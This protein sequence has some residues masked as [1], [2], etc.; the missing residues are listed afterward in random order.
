[1][2]AR[3]SNKFNVVN[4]SQCSLTCSRGI[5][6]TTILSLC[7]CECC[8]LVDQS[9]P[10]PNYNNKQNYEKGKQF[11]NDNNGNS[12]VE[13]KPCSVV[14]DLAFEDLIRL[15]IS[16]PH[17]YRS[18]KEFLNSKYLEGKL[19]AARNRPSVLSDNNQT[20]SELECFVRTPKRTWSISS[21]E[22]PESPCTRLGAGLLKG[23]NRFSNL[24]GVKRRVTAPVRYNPRVEKYRRANLKLSTNVSRKID[25]GEDSVPNCLKSC[26]V[27]VNRLKRENI[28]KEMDN[29][30]T[31]RALSPS[32]PGMLAALFS[33]K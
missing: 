16:L 2:T 22:P 8:P 18:V 17:R 28:K 5:I 24:R 19:R 6:D 10:V 7:T 15:N 25:S 31:Q 30:L 13:S 20:D 27:V 11:F 29:F 4:C 12:A 33:F 1:M 9:S 21:S 3:R 26:V 32:Y 23:P 14:L